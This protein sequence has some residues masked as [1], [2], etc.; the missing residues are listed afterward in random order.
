M[1]HILEYGTGRSPRV[2]R[3]PTSY[4]GRATVNAISLILSLMLLPYEI[5]QSVDAFFF[6]VFVGGP[7]LFVQIIFGGCPVWL[8]LICDRSGKR[9][10]LWVVFVL[11]LVATIVPLTGI[12]L[13]RFLPMTH[14]SIF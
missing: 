12:L 9:G 1:P 10:T 8:A 5:D 14:G 4:I 13:S 6:G 11:S 3:R 7:L 2:E